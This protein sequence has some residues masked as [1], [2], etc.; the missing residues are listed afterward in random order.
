MNKPAIGMIELTSIARGFSTVDAVVK[1]APVEI[2]ISKPISSGKYM[3]V[4]SGEVA[5]VEEALQ[6]GVEYGGARLVHHMMIANIHPDVIPAIRTPNRSV[7]YGSIGVVETQSV[8]ATVRAAD[9]AA[10]AAAIKLTAIQLGDGL[11]GK[12]YFIFTG[13]LPDVEASMETAINYA[14]PLGFLIGHE[15][16]PAP[17]D[18]LISVVSKE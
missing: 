11:G 18:D 9:Y 8:A 7:Q 17:H 5:C 3:L 6:A 2:L 1:K 14:E 16:I 12:G 15:L 13:E 4:F 10:K